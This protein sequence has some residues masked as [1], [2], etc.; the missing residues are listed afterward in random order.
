VALNLAGKRGREAR[1]RANQ[2]L[3]QVQLGH[4]LDFAPRNLSGG[5]KQRV[6]I[7]RALANRPRLLLADEPT[8]NL[9]SQTGQSIGQLIRD[10]AKN[11]GTGVV[12]VTHDNRI[13]NIADRIL[14]LEDGT[15]K[16][17]KIIGNA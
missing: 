10:L 15:L 5:E 17:E 2:V 1:E 11:E 4:R 13:E 14:Y 8:G 12:V 9:D 6:S 3:R 16:D 7:A